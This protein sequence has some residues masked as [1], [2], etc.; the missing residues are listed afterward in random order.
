M[1]KKEIEQH[2]KNLPYY[3]LGIAFSKLFIKIKK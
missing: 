1:K 2:K 3:I